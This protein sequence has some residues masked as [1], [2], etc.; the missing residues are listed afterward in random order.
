MG[1][2]DFLIDCAITINFILAPILFFA[3]LRALIEKRKMSKY[4]L[5]GLYLP[6]YFLFL[7]NS[8]FLLVHLIKIVLQG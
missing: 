3:A 6:L 7:I 1:L 5:G 2:Y 8:I 4:D